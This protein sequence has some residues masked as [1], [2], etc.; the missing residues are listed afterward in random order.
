ME[1]LQLAAAFALKVGLI[2]A[3]ASAL[4]VVLAGAVFWSHTGQFP[5]LHFLR[6]LGVLP[7]M[8]FGLVFPAVLLLEYGFP[9]T[10]DRRSGKTTYFP[11]AGWLVWPLKALLT[12]GTAYLVRHPR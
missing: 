2:F 12:A 11:G 10:T 5:V 7:L 6:A 9:R 3:A 4:K 1:R 8:G